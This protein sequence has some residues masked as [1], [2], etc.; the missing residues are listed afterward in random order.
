MAGHPNQ[1]HQTSP[2][3]RLGVFLDFKL[4]FLGHSENTLNEDSKTIGLLQ[5]S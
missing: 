2:Q 3:K 5:K 4:N 1:L